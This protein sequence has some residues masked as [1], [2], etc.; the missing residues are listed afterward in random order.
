MYVC[1]CNGFGSIDQ[2]LALQPSRSV[3]LPLLIYSFI[4]LNVTQDFS[5]GSVMV[6][7]NDPGDKVLDKLEP[8]SHTG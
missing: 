5:Y 6:V 3:V 1:I 2:A 4:S 7:Y 8:Y